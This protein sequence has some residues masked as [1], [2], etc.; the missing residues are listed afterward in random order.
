MIEAK[1]AF[2]VT[3]TESIAVCMQ[4]VR[5]CLLAI[6]DQGLISGSN[7]LLNLLL[8]RW[9][10]PEEYGAY[11]LAIS[12]FMLIAALHQALLME[13][14]VVFGPARYSGVQR[15]YLSS[16]LW[17]NGWFAAA[18]ALV[19]AGATFIAFAAG[20]RN[21]GTTTAGMIGA[22]PCILLFWLIRGAC[23][24]RFRPELAALGALI[25]A[26]IVSASVMVFHF[27]GLLSPLS[28]ILAMGLASLIVS[29]SLLPKLK[30]DMPHSAGGP[31]V[32]EVRKEHLGYGRWA[33]AAGVSSWVGENVWYWIIGLYVGVADVGALRAMGNLT[34]PMA[35]LVG[36]LSRL[37]LPHVS[38]VLKKEGVPAMRRVVYRMLGISLAASLVYLLIMVVYHRSIVAILYQGKFVDKAYLAV[39]LVGGFV[40]WVGSNSFYIGLRAMQ[41]PSAIFSA[42]GAAAVVAVV[43]AIVA[44][45]FYGLSGIAAG[46]VLSSMTSLIV[47]WRQFRSRTE[48]KFEAEAMEV[49]Q[50]V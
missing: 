19:L 34:L 27:I 17:L 7:F 39:W 18:A 21:W 33:M 36:A 37:T 5:K 40:V 14:M 2:A 25:Y 9:L 15:R 49:T 20:N 31:A 29:C 10:T 30:A 47:S 16:V 24:L 46:V 45:Y 35:H 4:W 11:V 23:Y 43:A 38:E 12:G 3:R 26:L 41:A 44:G 1:Q 22:V 28:A 48:S 8:A 6:S 50:L 42:T 13:P 32:W